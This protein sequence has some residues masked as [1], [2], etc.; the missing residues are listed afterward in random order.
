MHV[1]HDIVA[2][3]ENLLAPW[4]TQRH[5]EHRTVLGRVDFLTGE[6]RVDPLPQ[7]AGLGERE[8]Q[9]GRLVGDPLFRVIDVQ[10]AGVEHEPLAPAGV[11]RE[12]LAEVHAHLGRSVGGDLLPLR[13]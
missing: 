3:A 4:C 7:A 1:G 12:E 5:V 8:E 2:V 6:H 13:E 9:R 10:A 11:G